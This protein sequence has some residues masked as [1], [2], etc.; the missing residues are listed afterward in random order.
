MPR[1]C[2]QPGF[3]RPAAVAAAFALGL[4]LM[5][6]GV[7]PAFAQDEAVAAWAARHGAGS[8]QSAEAADQALREAQEQRQQVEARYVAQQNRCYDRFFVSYCLGKVA[9]WHRATLALI[10]PVEIEADVWKRRAKVEERDRNLEQQR[11]RDQ[12]DALQRAEQQRQRQADTAEK[13]ERKARETEATEEKSRQHQGEADRRIAEHEARLKEQ[14]RQEA[15]KAGERARNIAEYDRK[16]RESEARQREIAAK[17]AEK[18][19]QKAA[20]QGAAGAAATPSTP[21][22]P[23]PAA[24]SGKP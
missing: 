18:A 21:P 20:E 6:A 9:E 15:A 11:A 13:M 10:R 12:Q 23:A 7:P 5:L 19:R 14:Q 22:T 17:K 16:R 4:A 1:T 8:V 2:S 3:T 24:P